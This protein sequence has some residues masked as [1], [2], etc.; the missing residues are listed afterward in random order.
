MQKGQWEQIEMYWGVLLYTLPPHHY[1][2]FPP[3]LLSAGCPVV[4]ALVNCAQPWLKPQTSLK[5]LEP[6]S[7]TL[8]ENA[9]K[10]YLARPLLWIP[11]LDSIGKTVFDSREWQLRFLDD[12]GR[13]RGTQSL[14]QG[15]V[16]SFAIYEGHNLRSRNWDAQNCMPRK[17]ILMHAE[18]FTLGYLCGAECG[19]WES[20]FWTLSPEVVLRQQLGIYLTLWRES[21]RN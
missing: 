16:S 11:D 14:L 3:C 15:K 4:S 5:G 18:H 19:L 12:R 7:D 21:I 9:Q 13:K 2:P 1:L 10:L 6:I 8:W 17:C 20:K